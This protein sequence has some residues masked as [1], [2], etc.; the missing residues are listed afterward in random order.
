MYSV[1]L[2]MAMSGGGEVPAFHRSGG[3]YSSCGC[4]GYVCGGGGCCRGGRVCGGGGCCYG[5]RV[6]GGG[7]CCHG[8]Y[9]CCGGGMRSA[10]YPGSY[11]NGY[12]NG[13]VGAPNGMPVQD[14]RRATITVS[15]PADA[16]IFFDDQPTT[17]TSSRRVFITPPLEPGQY[18]YNVQANL[19]RN[20]KMTSLRKQV[21]VRPGENSQVSFE[22]PAAEGVAA[23]AP[24]PRT[25][26]A[27]APRTDA[28]ATPQPR[29]P[30]KAP[31]PKEKQ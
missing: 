18:T 16:R 8:G 24:Q 10:Y 14:S 26:T 28:P 6:S 9:A 5:G 11:S 3:G 21:A 17:S 12:A 31:L 25:E 23:P 15:V 29:E 2:M 19:E 13:Y 30:S 27:P 7:G 1:V 22:F 20:G 4:S